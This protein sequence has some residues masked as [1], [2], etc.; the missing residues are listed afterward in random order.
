MLDVPE[1]THEDLKWASRAWT[2]QERIFSRRLLIFADST[3]H[4]NCACVHW[5]EAEP[6]ASEDG[7]PPWKY[8]NNPVFRDNP[9]LYLK[10]LDLPGDNSLNFV[11]QNVVLT[12]VGLELSFEQD[13]LIAIAGMEN[14]IAQYFNTSFIFGHP[15]KNFVDFLLW[16]PNP[17]Q[18][19]RRDAPGI[20]SWSWAG[21]S[22]L[23]QFLLFGC[24]MHVS[25][26]NS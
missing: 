24:V 13:I 10:G 9:I 21:V 20:P 18:V 19:R 12:V 8:Y 14:Y 16:L 26:F 4:W 5:S 23:C 3:V 2:F 17:S 1:L 22:I 15:T 6:N 25:S 11:W 7:P